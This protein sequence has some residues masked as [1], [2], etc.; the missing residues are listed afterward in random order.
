MCTQN[1]T[2]GSFNRAPTWSKSSSSLH[3]LCLPLLVIPFNSISPSFPPSLP[4]LPHSLFLS[5]P[6]FFPLSLC[7]SVSLSKWI[8]IDVVNH[9]PDKQQDSC[10]SLCFLSF[11][12]PSNIVVIIRLLHKKRQIYW[13]SLIVYT[14]FCLPSFQDSCFVIC[15]GELELQALWR[16]LAIYSSGK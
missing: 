4:S 16:F 8:T 2:I 10:P 15:S 1:P 13:C 7:L 14:S 12:Q 6:S 3:A 11:M 9:H 5:F